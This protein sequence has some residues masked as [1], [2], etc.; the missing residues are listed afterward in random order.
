MTRKLHLEASSI[1]GLLGKT[2]GSRGS[3]ARPSA[4]GNRGSPDPHCDWWIANDVIEYHLY[5]YMIYSMIN[6]IILDSDIVY[7]MFI[8]LYSY[9]YTHIYID[10]YIIYIYIYIHIYIL[11]SPFFALF[12]FRWCITYIFITHVLQEK[13]PLTKAETGTLWSWQRS[14]LLGGKGSWLQLSWSTFSR[15]CLS[16]WW[17]TTFRL[18]TSKLHSRCNGFG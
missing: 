1:L 3:G 11:T 12:A 17:I 10:T 13:S 2:R 6:M 9:L 7:I 16:C 5:V 18:E 4:V 14:L 8:F 15:A